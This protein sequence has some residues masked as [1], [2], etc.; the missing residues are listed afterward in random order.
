M[1]VLFAEYYPETRL[2]Q[3]FWPHLLCFNA[4]FQYL[5]EAFAHF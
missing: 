5:A 2:Y 1:D 3:I 4:D